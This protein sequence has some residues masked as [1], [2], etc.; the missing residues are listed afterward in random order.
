MRA[1]PGSRAELPHVPAHAQRPASVAAYQCILRVLR[2]QAPADSN[3]TQYVILDGF[4]RR[5]HVDDGLPVASIGLVVALASIPGLIE[6]GR[7]RRVT[8][9]PC[10]TRRTAPIRPSERSQAI[11]G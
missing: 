1:R 2:G 3:Q 9:P 6:K 7:Y 10:E 5:L 4:Q 8:G 11:A